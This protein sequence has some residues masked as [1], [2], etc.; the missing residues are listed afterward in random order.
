MFFVSH[1]V[2]WWKPTAKSLTW[3]R[4]VPDPGPKIRPGSGARQR[5][6]RHSSVHHSEWTWKNRC[7]AYECS[8]RLCSPSNLSRNI[9][10]SVRVCIMANYC[11]TFVITV[12]FQKRFVREQKKLEFDLDSSASTCLN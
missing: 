5:M 4:Q 2:I 12:S 9:P 11:K 1:P 7:M 8:E 10:S 3:V 6:T